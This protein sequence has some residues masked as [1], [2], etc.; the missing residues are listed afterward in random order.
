MNHTRTGLALM[1]WMVTACGGLP[2]PEVARNKPPASTATPP[3]A[4]EPDA[5]ESGAPDPAPPSSMRLVAVTDATD[6][7]LRPRVVHDDE[8]IV[9]LPSE[10][11][12]LAR[13]EVGLLVTRR[14]TGE[15]MDQQKKV[16]SWDTQGPALHF[17]LP[18]LPG[19][20][21]LAEVR[22]NSTMLAR[23]GEIVTQVQLPD[24]AQISVH[25]DREVHVPHA[26]EFRYHFKLHHALGDSP[27]LA[28]DRSEDAD[29]DLRIMELFTKLHNNDVLKIT[30]DCWASSDGEAEYN[31]QVSIKRCQWVRSHILSKALDSLPVTNIIEA[32]HGED[33]PPEPEPAGVTG[34]ALQEIQRRNRVVI[35][36]VYTSN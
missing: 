3:G 22:T 28:H 20:D 18:P 16:F 2:Q 12:H 33:N 24:E 25:S 34:H 4:P 31:M 6:F 30:L 10:R 35:L 9:P 19:G 8:I 13:V 21:Y 29:S 26:S 1:C 7:A 36:K 15:I 5:P 17:H 27:E 32:A 23:T 11:A 14:D